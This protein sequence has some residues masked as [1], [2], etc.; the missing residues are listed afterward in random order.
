MKIRAVLFDLDGT[1]VDS[2]ED[3]AVALNEAL[4]A[5]D[6]G[7]LPLEAILPMIGDGARAL[8]TRAGSDEARARNEDESGGY[9]AP[10][11]PTRGY[12]GKRDLK[13]R[14]TAED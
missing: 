1:L 14:D 11:R 9:G 13:P 12:K 7:A 6:L 5:H 10:R 3:I 8:V 4:S 2:R